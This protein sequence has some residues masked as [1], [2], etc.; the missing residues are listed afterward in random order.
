VSPLAAQ[1]LGCR[2]GDV[3]RI[4]DGDAEVVGIA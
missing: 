4:R 2:V 1:L 3:V